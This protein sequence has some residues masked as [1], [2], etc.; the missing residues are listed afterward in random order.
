[1]NQPKY[2]EGV[3]MHRP[4]PDG[5]LLTVIPLTY[6]RARINRGSSDGMFYDDGW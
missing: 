3:V 5:R 6:S 2:L 4:A 1:M